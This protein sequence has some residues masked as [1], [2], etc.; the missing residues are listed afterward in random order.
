[1]KNEISHEI[2]A[3]YIGGG[4]IQDKEVLNLHETGIPVF[5][6]PERAMRAISALIKYKNF[7]QKY[8][9]KLEVKK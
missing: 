6:T 8:N 7:L 4:D 5:P 9:L 1:M 2:V 3:C